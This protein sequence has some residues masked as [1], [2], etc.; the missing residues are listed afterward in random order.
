MRAA[1]AL[2]CAVCLTSFYSC[3]TIKSAIAFQLCL[4]E[5]KMV[6]FTVAKRQEGI[7]LMDLL[8]EE[9]PD[10]HVKDIGAD[11]KA[12]NI[13]LRGAAAYGDDIPDAGDEVRIFAPDDV[14]G[15]DL[16]PP[17]VYSDENFVIV[18]KPAGLLSFSD[19]GS[20]NA[21]AMV[22]E[23]MKQKGE[24]SLGALMVPYLVYPLDKYVNGLLL[25]AKHEDAYLF[26]VE[27]LAQR[28]IVRH[29]VCPVV[30]R[31][32]QS[33]EMMAYH[34]TDKTN[35]R[36]TILSRFRKN[37]KP[38]VTRYQTI[39]TGRAMSLVDVRPLT[40]GLHQIRAQMADAGLP[41]VGD[42]AYGDKRFNKK[43]GADHI[44]LW[45]ESVTF[46]VGTGH[47][48][49]YLNGRHF[50]SAQPCFPRCVYEDGLMEQFEQ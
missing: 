41:V 11:F 27:A 9:Y 29:Y 30:G 1:T 17:V 14:I 2:K 47:A 50:E 6:Y 15:I 23:Y 43:A 26:M 37:A 35:R 7:P 8:K 22:E 28:R 24:Y 40:N 12:G 33:D 21:T 19:D 45:L 31:T 16:T 38:I 18:D 49:P 32:E 5:R 4:K 3:Y 34:V 25:L 39:A 13:W 48:Y 46:E 20:P 44:A 42:N 36:A 10:Y